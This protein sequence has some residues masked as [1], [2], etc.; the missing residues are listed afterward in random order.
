MLLQEIEKIRL[1]P[2]A[3]ID[4]QDQALPLA[5]LLE[6][7]GLPCV[8]VTLRTEE[9]LAALARMAK[10]SS[11]L[12]GAGTVLTLDQAKAAVD[13]G[14]Q[15]LVSPGL[16]T[17]I[18][19]WCLKQRVVIIPGCATAS[20][21]QLALEL[22]LNT[23]KFF[24]AEQLGGVTM[25]AALGAV[26]QGIHFMPTGGIGKHNLLQYLS[27][28]QVLACGGSWM[29]RNDWLKSGNLHLIAEEIAASTALLASMV[30]EE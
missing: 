12:V 29:V 23:V 22:G 2:V 17:R 4:S 25:L 16:S 21:I 11:L 9:A 8:E 27:L 14:A 20:E 5:K 15:F 6:S 24:P 18:V 1:V 10:H 7:G 13:H 30:K 19:E 26:F 3:I 28:P